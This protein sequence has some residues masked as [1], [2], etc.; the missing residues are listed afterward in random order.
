MSDLRP[1]HRCPA[2]FSLT[3]APSTAF[4][5]MAEASSG[6]SILGQSFCRLMY[7]F[8]LPDE[9]SRFS[10]VRPSA[11]ICRLPL[12]LLSP[13]YFSSISFRLLSP[14]S[15]L[16]YASSISLSI[17]SLFRQV[18]LPPL[19]C[20]LLPP[21]AQLR[22]PLICQYCCCFFH[23]VPANLHAA[24]WQS[25]RCFQLRQPSLSAEF[26]RLSP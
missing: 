26:P 3:A 7:V 16:L 18:L 25:F 23:V 15:L 22:P 11:V 13:A 2:V 5:S 12:M 6:I 14:F 21:R 9:R 17:F 19:V 20:L 10:P 24:C 1:N 4:F 8:S